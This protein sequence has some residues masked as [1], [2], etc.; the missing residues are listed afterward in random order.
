M[1]IPAHSQEQLTV[2]D[3]TKID[4]LIESLG[5]RYTAT[6]VPWSKSRS[7]KADPKPEDYNINWR[8]RVAKLSPVDGQEFRGALETDYSLG[9]GH[10]PKAVQP[11]SPWRMSIDEY[12]AIKQTCETGRYRFGNSG[13]LEAPPLR[14]VL[15]SL[16][17]DS[18]VINFDSFESWASEFGYDADSRA[19]EKTYRAC[20]E[21]AIKLRNLVGDADLTKLRDAYQDY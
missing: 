8:V 2:T 18:D 3:H 6:F 5:L 20:L 7:A 21:I 13:R 15:H 16:V 12:D 11:K 10:L 4:A 1:R 17:S 19:A 9:T 14:D